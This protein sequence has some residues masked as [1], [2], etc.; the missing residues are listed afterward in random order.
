[1][2]LT[3]VERNLVVLVVIMGVVVFLE[4]LDPVRLR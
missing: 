1:M 3:V 4:V 2:T